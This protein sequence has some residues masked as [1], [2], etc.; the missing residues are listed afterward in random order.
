MLT[1]LEKKL[2][3]LEQFKG[4]DF[5]DRGLD[6]VNWYDL[7]N[8]FNSQPYKYDTVI[9]V[10]TYSGHLP[11]LKQTLKS[12]LF[13]G[14][15]VLCAYDHPFDG[16]S[17]LGQGQMKTHFLRPDHLLLPHAWVFK[18]KTYDCAKRNGWFWNLRYAQ[19][20]INQFP[21]IKY[22]FT[23]NGDCI[24]DKPEGVDEIIRILGDG[25]LIAQAS[26]T[27]KG[28][29]GTLHTASVMYKIDAFNKIM[30]YIT[31]CMKTPI[32]GSNSAEVVLRD[33]V[34][35][36]KLKEVV[37][38]KQPIYPQDG[39]IDMYCCYNQE[40]TWKDVLGF[41]NLAAEMETACEERLEPLPKHYLDD[42]ED[43]IYFSSY[44]RATICNYYRTGDR[45]YI[46]QYWSQS[47]DSWYDRRYYPIEYY[48]KD[49]ILKKE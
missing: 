11:W 18:H 25:D 48:G 2:A 49:P 3:G 34:A 47:A 38:P 8:N 44:E 31:D 37:A 35:L 26:D 1:K 16:M 41:R 30:E 13:T 32:I 6:G 20:I 36:L 23:V 24:F 40:S 21:N 22:V 46:Y 42:F 43:Y 4:T 39:S 17:T 5:M 19:G 12:Y 29:P 14:K 28:T 10:P 33:A 9:L 15:V 7:S 45:R 27:K